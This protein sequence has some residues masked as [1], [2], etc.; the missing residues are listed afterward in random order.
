MF[1]LFKRKSLEEDPAA[2]PESNSFAKELLRGGGKGSHHGIP[3]DVAC[4]A[5]DHNSGSLAV[6]TTRGHIKVKA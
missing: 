3:G 6:G 2:L 5:Y 4:V 1:G